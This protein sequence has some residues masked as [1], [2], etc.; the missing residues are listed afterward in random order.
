MRI[1]NAFILIALL[2]P[3]LSFGQIKIED[4]GDGWKPLVDSAI[5]LIRDND[6]D[7]YNLL[8]SHCKSVEFIIS[9]RST[10]KPPDVIA[11]STGDLKL[12][13]VNNIAAI[14]VHESYHLYLCSSSTKMSEREEE[15]AAYLY[16]YGFLCNLPNVEDWLFFNNIN[17][18][19]RYQADPKR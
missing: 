9:D 16:E 19:I 8:I 10:T 1:T 7:K 17:M 14:L 2:F 6:R 4:V 18:I 13:S 11:I 15:L 12:R 5:N 3:S